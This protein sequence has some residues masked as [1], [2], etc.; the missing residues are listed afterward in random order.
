[1]KKTRKR[2]NPYRWNCMMLQL[3]IGFT[4]FQTFGDRIS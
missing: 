3:T 2:Y 4:P 1:M